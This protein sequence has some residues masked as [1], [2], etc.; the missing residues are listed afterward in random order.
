MMRVLNANPETLRKIDDVLMGRD[1]PVLNLRNETRLLTLTEVAE[2]LNISRPS[3]YR[4]L[5]A[6]RLDSVALDGVN[7]VTLRSVME[8]SLGMREDLSRKVVAVMKGGRV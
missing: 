1:R 7:R 4:L 2:R 5:K 6:G 8:L 3:V